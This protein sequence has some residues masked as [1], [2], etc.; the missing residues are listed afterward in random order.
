MESL[1]DG[2][3]RTSRWLRRYDW[4]WE[5]R[6]FPGVD[7]RSNALRA[8][9]Y[10]RNFFYHVH[11]VAD[12]TR[13]ATGRLVE[14]S[15][16]LQEIF[17]LHQDPAPLA[18]FVEGSSGRRHGADAVSEVLS[19]LISRGLLVPADEEE[20]LDT[21]AV[22]EAA[23]SLCVSIQV[24]EEHVRAL[25][26]V[27]EHAPKTVV[28]IGTAGG[29]TL[30]G[31]AQVAQ[32]D[33]RLVSVDL[34]GGVGGGGYMPHHEPL[35]RS[36]CA[37][38]QQLHCVLGDSTSP[39]VIQRVHSAHHGAPV[40]LLFIDGDHSYEGAR[41][42][43]ANYSGLVPKGGMILFHDIQPP[44][45]DAKQP[46]GVWRFWRE[47]KDDYRHTEIVHDPENQFSAGFGVLYV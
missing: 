38:D 41:D 17:I 43:F 10:P 3:W 27:K 4:D 8:A 7:P 21:A 16:G 18:A 2:L 33:A 40:D 12:A 9:T 19:G 36:F 26:V 13:G 47:I 32:P 14:Y 23:W 46:M 34:P 25:D 31:W 6:P 35:F 22:A 37:P 45:P 5:Q 15:D 28:E 11:A 39:G 24:R 42:D 30:F 44:P 29:G 20:P 1:P